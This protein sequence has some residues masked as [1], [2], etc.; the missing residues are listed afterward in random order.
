MLHGPGGRI[1]A[2]AAGSRQGLPRVWDGTARTRAGGW[3]GGRGLGRCPG[4]GRHPPRLAAA[5][6][7]PSWS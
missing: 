1:N 5:M 7:D 6:Y 2:Y 3:R 4:A